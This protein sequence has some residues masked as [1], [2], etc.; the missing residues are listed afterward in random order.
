MRVPGRHRFEATVSAYGVSAQLRAPDSEML[1][2]VVGGLPRAWRVLADGSATSNRIAASF[3]VL[4]EPSGYLIRAADGAEARYADREMTTWMLR[5]ML[6]REVTAGIHYRTCIAA[7]VVTYGGRAIMLPTRAFAGTTKLVTALI[8]AGAELHAEE[9][10][11]LDSDGRLGSDL[12][13]PGAPQ[14]AVPLG[15]AAV[16][17]YR[18]GA[19]WAPRQMSQ[20]EGV[21]TLMAYATTRERPAETLAALRQALDDVP[22]FEGDRGEADETAVMLLETLES[23]RRP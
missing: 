20:A 15:L 13:A 6:R 8:A 9:F 7:S 1:E 19:V 2:S 18:P 12:E 3:T 17:V 23:G 4:R 16:T 5:R 22:I 21:V 11:V 14:R 10:A